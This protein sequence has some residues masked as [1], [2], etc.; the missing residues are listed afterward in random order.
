MEI[1]TISKRDNLMITVMMFGSFI[2]VLNQT[3]LTTALPDI[4]GAFKLDSSEGQWLTTIFMLVNGIMIPLTAYFTE[5]YTAKKLFLTA[6][7]L[8]ILGSL[9]CFLAPGFYVMLLGRVVQAAGA[10]I[11]M[12]LMQ[13]V[14]FSVY[15]PER[16]GAAMGVFGLVIGF[17]PAIGPTVS[18]WIVNSYSFRVL[19]AII[20]VISVLIF[21]CGIFTVHDVYEQERIALDKIS[22]IQ[23]TFGFGGLLLGF[24][25]A[26]QVGFLSTEVIVTLIISVA[27]LYALV[28]RQ[29]KLKQPLLEFR[30]FQYKGFIMSMSIIVVMFMIFISNMTILPIFMQQSMGVSPLTSGLVILPGGLLMGL[31]SPVSGRLYDQFGA[32]RLAIVG[33]TLISISLLL[34]AFMNETPSLVSIIIKFAILMTGNAMIMTPMTSAAINALPRKYITHGTAM[35][36]TIR[37]I[38]AAIG[39]A[40]F[41]TIMNL[42]VQSGLQMNITY[43]SMFIFSLFG[44]VLSLGYPKNEKSV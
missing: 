37:Q 12:P 16:R 5:R 23:S 43:I 26:G 30:V 24:S 3:L 13:V 44:L 33:M 6:I 27:A 15:P 40:I 11:L 1:H 29:L 17:A 22:V 9:V 34:F 28:N 20:F 36:N 35:N 32:K 25:R 39:T 19:F 7:G 14:L 2:A 8:F 41:I 4:M 18:G 42:A 10:G 38:S 31:L 21:I